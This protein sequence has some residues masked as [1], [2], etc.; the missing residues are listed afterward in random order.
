MSEPCVRCGKLM[1]RCHL[2]TDGDDWCSSQVGAH[3]RSFCSMA[4]ADAW[5][6]DPANAD[7]MAESYRKGNCSAYVDCV[8]AA[9]MLDVQTRARPRFASCEAECPLR[10]AYRS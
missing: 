2:D 1:S 5:E 8:C 10:Q 4:C 9:M 6:K 7:A 3:G